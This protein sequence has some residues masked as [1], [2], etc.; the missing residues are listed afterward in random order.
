MNSRRS[1][2][3]TC[4]EVEAADDVISAIR[5]KECAL[6]VQNLRR[7][8]ELRTSGRSI[9]VPAT[10]TNERRHGGCLPIN[11]ADAVVVCVRL[12]SNLSHVGFVLCLTTKAK[13]VSGE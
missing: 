1:S 6:P 5:N 12:H 9:F 7:T 8:V 11:E 13:P 2:V 4:L 3:V 10:A